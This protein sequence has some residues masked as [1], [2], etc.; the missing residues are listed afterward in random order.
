[1]RVAFL[2]PFYA[3]RAGDGRMPLRVTYGETL[4]LTG[5][6][7]TDRELYDLALDPHQLDSLHD[8]SSPVRV[9]QRRILKRDLEALKAC[10]AG[11]CQSLE[12]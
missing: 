8:D 11:T 3:V 10:S 2:P 6:R 9:Q 1:M 4:D 5:T 7:V 12:Q